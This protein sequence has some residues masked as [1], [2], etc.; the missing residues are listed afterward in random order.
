LLRRFNNGGKALNKKLREDL[1]K[2]FKYFWQ[3]NRTATLL[4]KKE[5]FDALPRDIKRK[6]MTEYLYQDVFSERRFKEFIDNGE[7]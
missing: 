7:A 3:H 2:H 6:M 5:Y 4:E 1:M